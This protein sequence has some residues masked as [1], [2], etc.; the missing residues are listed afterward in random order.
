MAEST[1]SPL[2]RLAAQVYGR[3]VRQRVQMD[4]YGLMP[5]VHLIKWALANSR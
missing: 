4:F 5:E 2:V 3:I 1:R